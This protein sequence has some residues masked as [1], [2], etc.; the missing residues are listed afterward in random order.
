MPRNLALWEAEADRSLE[1]RSLRTAW[2]TWQNL[3]CTKNTKKLAS[4]SAIHLYSQLL[5]RLRH[6]KNHL[7]WQR[8]AVSQ[9]CITILQP[10]W[11]GETL[12]QL[13]RKKN[14]VSCFYDFLSLSFCIP[15]VIE[16]PVGPSWEQSSVTW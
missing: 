4:Y 2:P 14:P 15:N 8:L 5:G 16:R 3:I 10:R 9:D 1:V 7:G 12:P 11:Q 13:K 6:K